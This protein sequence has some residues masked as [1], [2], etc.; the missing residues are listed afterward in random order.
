MKIWQEKFKLSW[1]S[2]KKIQIVMKIWQENSN[3]HENLTRKFKLSWTSDKKIQIVRKIWQ[4]NSN[5]HENLT[6]RLKS[7]WKSVKGIQIVMKIWQGDSNC[8]EN[9]TRKFKLSWKSDKKIQS[10]MKIWQENWNCHEN[11]SRIKGTLSKDQYTYFVISWWILL[12]MR[13]I[14]EKRRAKNQN[15]RFLSYNFIFCFQKSWSLW[16]NVE[17]YFKSGQITANCITIIKRRQLMLLREVNTILSIIHNTYTNHVETTHLS[18][19]KRLVRE[20]ASWI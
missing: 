13:N 18:M 15:T 19:S 8:H 20:I 17:K 6:R 4:E 12:W 10:V 14:S 2:D 3:C 16:N 11:L 7:S 5:C 9:L 1:K